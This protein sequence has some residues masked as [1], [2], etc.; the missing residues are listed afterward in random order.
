[1]SDVLCACDRT[2]VT[3]TSG[4]MREGRKADVPKVGYDVDLAC[5][6]PLGRVKCQSSGL[7][8]SSNRIRLCKRAGWVIRVV[9]VGG[10]VC[11][12]GVY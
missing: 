2:E 4:W 9:G 12:L 5:G 3:D 10:G 1:M 8:K 11:R 6:V 7:S